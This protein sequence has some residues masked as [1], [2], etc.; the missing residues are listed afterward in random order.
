MK[1]SLFFLLIASILFANESDDFKNKQLEKTKDVKIDISKK[2]DKS[3]LDIDVINNAKNR[4]GAISEQSFSFEKKE[5]DLSDVKKFT[6]GKEFKQNLQ[7]TRK[8]IINDDTM[9]YKKM[10]APV[11]EFERTANEGL[12]NIKSNKAVPKKRFIEGE[13]LTIFISSSMDK[14][15]IKTYFRAFKNVNQ[16]VEFVL[17][18]VLPN[19]GAKIMPTIN[20]IKELLGDEYSY[21][22]TINPVKFKDNGIDKVPAILYNNE[23]DI[24]IYTGAVAPSEALKEIYNKNTTENKTLK[25]LIDNL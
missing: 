9:L 12:K 21:S 2:D 13:P 16:D 7:L 20:Y 14:E 25:P 19:T 23:K 8:S 6:E 1:T 18:G 22:V 24:Y 17:N 10:E 4:S 15:L 11:K 3:N 5:T